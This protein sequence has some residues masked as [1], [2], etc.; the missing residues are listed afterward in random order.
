[1]DRRTMW[2]HSG[3]DCIPFMV[4]AEPHS[5][6]WPIGEPCPQQPQSTEVASSTSTMCQRPTGECPC[7]DD[8][9]PKPMVLKVDTTFLPSDN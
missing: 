3:A 5:A 8:A 1:M 7:A 4:V 6:R 2:L 9:D